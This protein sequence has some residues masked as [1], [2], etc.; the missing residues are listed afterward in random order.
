[1]LNIR[2]SNRFESLLDLLAEQAREQ[3]GDVFVP[4]TII[5]PSAAVQR[6]VTLHLAEQLGV[7]ANVD[8]NYPAIWIW[9]QIARAVPGIASDSPFNPDVLVWRVYRALGDA[10]FVAAHPRLAA[11][12]ER[13]DD[14]MRFELAARSASLLEQ[15]I[16]YRPDWMARWAASADVR[17]SA[18][19]TK[20]VYMA[21]PTILKMLPL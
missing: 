13:S 17:A 2:L 11:Y 15:Y 20:T 14:V 19:L 7:C 21:S 9:R 12:L 8:F 1:M 16:T 5:V 4:M 6:A 10:D 3:L 18:A